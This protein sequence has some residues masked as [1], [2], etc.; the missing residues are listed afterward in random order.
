MAAVAA[1]ATATAAPAS[2]GRRTAVGRETRLRTQSQAASARLRRENV[3]VGPLASCRRHAHREREHRRPRR[4][5]ARPR[6]PGHRVTVSIDP[7]ALVARLRYSHH[8]ER[9]FAR[10]PHTIR[11]V[12]C[13]RARA[14]S[15][16]DGSPVRFFSGFSSCAARRR[17]CRDDHGRSAG[18]SHLRLRWPTAPAARR[19][20]PACGHDPDVHRGARRL[21]R[22]PR[23][24]ARAAAAGELRGDLRLALLAAD[25]RRAPW[26]AG[27]CASWSR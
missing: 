5:R 20:V 14:G 9:P 7:S 3:V 16:V 21:P 25:D 2:A 10:L 18:A 4:L 13:D 27:C 1:V 24:A 19:E 11:L 17:A 6:A 12:A 26:S 23:H 8:G 15:D 22:R